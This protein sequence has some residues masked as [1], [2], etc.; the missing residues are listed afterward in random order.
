MKS[1]YEYRAMA[2][3][4]LAGRW[5]ESAMAY[6]VILGIAYLFVGSSVMVP[7]GI[8]WAQGTVGGLQV[9]LSILLI[10]PLTYGFYNAMLGMSRDVSNGAAHDMFDYFS[11]DYSRS[12]PANFLV[13]LA[14]IGLGVI[15]LGI[16][17][18][19]LQY[20]YA[21]VPYLLKDYPELTATEALRTSRQMMKGHKWDLFVL[22]LSF[23]GWI[24][25]SICTLCIGMLWVTPYMYM[26]HA[27]F[28]ENLK[29]EMIVEE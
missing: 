25:L 6:L 19:V 18:I 23:I 27:H 5:N 20:A 9:A 4:T 12:V 1:S 15:T 17:A 28:Y 2:R 26:A 16:G 29:A 11:Q 10:A 21:M 3:E 7:E 13:Y 8:V 22:D 14:E 24:L